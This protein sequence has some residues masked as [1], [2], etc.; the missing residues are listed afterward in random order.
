MYLNEILE[1]KNISMYRLSKESN[2]PQTTIVDICSRKTKIE[3]CTAETLYKIAKALNVTMESLIENELVKTDNM[4]HRTDFGVFKSNVCHLVKDKGDIDFLIETLEK[5]EVRDLY[6]RRRYAEAFYM[7]GMI[8]YLSRENDIPICTDYNDLRHQKLAK[9]LY[10]S[11]VV[12]AD[13]ISQTDKEKKK[14]MEKAIPEFLKFNI[15]ECEVR[16]VC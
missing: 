11:G 15:V 12:L 9:P 3:K 1:E 4:E 2:V 5:D 6:N 10:P 7:L 8:D 13:S 16:D 14:A